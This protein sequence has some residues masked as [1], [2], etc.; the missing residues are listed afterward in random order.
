MTQEKQ[1]RLPFYDFHK[2]YTFNAIFNFICGARGLGKTYGWKKRAIRNAIKRGDEFIYLRRYKEEL[3]AARATFFDDVAVEFPDHIFRIHA[4][5]AQCAEV[6]EPVEN[7]QGELVTPKPEWRTIGY[8]VALSNAQAR[9]S[10]SYSKVKEICYDEFII[11]K[12]MVHYLP[13]EHIALLNFYNTVDRY[14]EQVRV[15]LLANAVTMT[16]P[17][18]DEYDIRP[19]QLGE[20]STHF[21]NADGLPFICVHF[22]DSKDFQ[23][24]VYRTRFGQFIADSDY[25]KYAVGNEFHD[26]HDQLVARKTPT[27]KHRY[28]LETARG[29][30]SVWRDLEIGTYFILKRLPKDGRIFTTVQENMGEG[31]TYLEP[32]HQLL[33]ML[34]SAFNNGKVFFDEPA[35]RN[36]FVNA[37]RK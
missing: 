5:N 12:G 34:R 18:F 1:Q 4:G 32:S 14:R 36:K 16:N 24:A 25:A 19:D 29:L 28:N 35:T 31:K 26:S 27:A 23:D 17:Y 11:E 30:F 7:D 3:S 8:F 15:F 21:K 9:K 10:V 13:D 6:V 2:V 37:I 22:P 33:A 20:W